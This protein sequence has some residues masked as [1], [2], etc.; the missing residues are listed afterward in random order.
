VSVWQHFE[1]MLRERP[2]SRRSGFLEGREL[3]AVI[4][5]GTVSVLVLK[6]EVIAHCLVSDICASNGEATAKF[7]H[8][9]RKSR[10]RVAR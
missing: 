8:S 7:L 2:R 3:N 10:Q 5:N 9:Q 4:I 6:I 1:R